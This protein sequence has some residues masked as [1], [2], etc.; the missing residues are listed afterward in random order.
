MTEKRQ[1]NMKRAR[2]ITL[3]GSAFIAY[4][5]YNSSIQEIQSLNTTRNHLNK[6][7][8]YNNN[9]VDCNGNPQERRELV[10]NGDSVTKDQWLKVIK[11]T[12]KRENN[13]LGYY[14]LHVSKSGG[15]FI[16]LS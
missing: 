2:M 4:F 10:L 7:K 8:K 1:P 5:T 3:V 9:I 12:N 14:A 15:E 6:E 13:L 11:C 16:S